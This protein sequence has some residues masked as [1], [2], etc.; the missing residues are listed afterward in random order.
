MGGRESRDRAE[1][2]VGGAVRR[3]GSWECGVVSVEKLRSCSERS[4]N[5]GREASQINSE[6][7]DTGPPPRCAGLLLT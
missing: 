6:I 4:D 1:E 7:R 5:T 3:V 2:V